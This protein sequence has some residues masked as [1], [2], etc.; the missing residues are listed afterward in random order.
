M[1]ISKFHARIPRASYILCLLVCID[2][3]YVLWFKRYFTRPIH[4]IRL[5]Y[6]NLLRFHLILIVNYHNKEV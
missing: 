5:Q 4:T 6:T 2:F 1:A 3:P